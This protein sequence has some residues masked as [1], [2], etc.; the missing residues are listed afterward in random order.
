[1]RSGLRTRW[2]LLV[3]ARNLLTTIIPLF[4]GGPLLF[5]LLLSALAL[6]RG[7]GLWS[8]GTGVCAAL[9]VPTLLFHVGSLFPPLPVART[10]QVHLFWQLQ[11][12]FRL[13]SLGFDVVLLLW[14]TAGVI[15]LPAWATLVAPLI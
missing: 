9:V 2:L 4:L 12:Q 14:G 3:A 11:V 7:S 1:L 5:L 15:V 8:L 13:R 6:A 10:V